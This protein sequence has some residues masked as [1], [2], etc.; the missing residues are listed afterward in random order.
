M[1]KI[2]FVMPTRNRDQ[3]IGESIESIVNQ[4]E[5]DWELVIVDDHSDPS[6][7]TETIV[8]RFNDKRIK[9]FRL[10]D[11]K[12]RHVS[13]A[14]NFGNAMSSGAII[15]VCDSDDIYIKKRAKL[16]LSTQKKEKWDIFYG[17]YLV[18]KQ[19]KELYEDTANKQI[20]FD[21]MELKKRNFIPN[22][23]TAYLR[24]IAFQYPYNSYLNR[25]ED[26][27][28]F[29]RLAKDNKRFFFCNEYIF[30][31]RVHEDSVTAGSVDNEVDAFIKK[32]RG[33]QND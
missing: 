23:S 24:E 25:S 27:D 11:I 33:W 14:R 31:Y 10:P 18:F 13:C 26:Y 16:I 19:D 2:S 30:K 1:P 15:A 7:N 4:S 29:S 12:G 6:D 22:S 5:K 8:A 21:L 20:P 17:K 32:N 9:F 3:L 28:F